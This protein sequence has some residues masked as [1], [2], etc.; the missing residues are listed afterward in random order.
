MNCPLIHIAGVDILVPTD[1]DIAVRSSLPSDSL[2]SSI[3][4][5]IRR[6]RHTYEMKSKLLTKDHRTNNNLLPVYLTPFS[7]NSFF[8]N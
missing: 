7:S 5:Y 3:A 8:A 6:V 2:S 4:V 1:S